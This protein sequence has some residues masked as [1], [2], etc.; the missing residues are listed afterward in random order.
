M[1]KIYFLLLL[2]H[3][4]MIKLHLLLLKWVLLDIHSISTIYLHLLRLGHLL[5]LLHHWRINLL[6][7]EELL[8]ILG[9]EILTG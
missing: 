7:I 6:E 1:P 4:A 2:K 9:D 8:N 5:R 3:N